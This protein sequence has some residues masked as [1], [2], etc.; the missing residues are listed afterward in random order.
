MVSGDDPFSTITEGGLSGTTA[1]SRAQLPDNLGAPGTLGVPLTA[2]RTLA[3]DKTAIP[4]GTPVFLATTDPVTDQ[5]LDR[6][7]IAQDTDGGLHGVSQADLFFGA[8]PEAEATAG[9][10]HQQ[11]TLYLLLPKQAPNS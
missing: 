5:P 2:D 4:L 7:V 11:G 3:V 9:R 10:M 8:G 1:S 6:L